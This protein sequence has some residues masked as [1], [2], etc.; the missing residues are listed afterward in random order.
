MA[1]I[2]PIDDTQMDLDMDEDQVMEEEIP[3]DSATS[4]PIL[5]PPPTGEKKSTLPLPGTL[6]AGPYRS[7]FALKVAET[8]PEVLNCLE[9]VNC[10]Y[11]STKG[12]P[13]TLLQLKQ[14]AQSL[15]VLIK[16]MTVSTMAAVIDNRN[17]PGEG[18]KEFHENES[19]DWLNDL[20]EPYKNG[21]RH[22]QMPLTSLLNTV[23]PPT[24]TNKPYTDI[25][26]MH[27]ADVRTPR[28]GIS[29]PYAT[30]QSLI[31]HANEVLELLD[32]EYSAKGGL[33]SILPSQ[34]QKEDRAKAETTLLGQLILYT[35]RLV[36]RV[37]DLEREYANSLDIIAGEAAVPLQALSQL[38]PH[39]RQPRELVYPQDRFVLVNA[40]DDVWQFLRNE[41]ERKEAA[42]EEADFKHY[43]RGITGEALWRKDGDQEFARG[44]TALD[45]TTRYYRLR[46]DPLE[47]VF[48]IPAYQKHPGTKVTREM[49]RQPTVVSVVKP[50]WPERA[51]MWEM[52]HRDDMEELKRLRSEHFQL[53]MDADNAKETAKGVFQDQQLKAQELRELKAKGS[54]A[55]KEAQVEVERLNAV[56]KDPINEVRMRLVEE[57][58][59]VDEVRMKT[60]A[61]EEE[62]KKKTE[63]LDQELKKA[64]EVTQQN[65]ELKSKEKSRV[66]RMET[67]MQERMR[68]NMERIDARD[69]EAAR[70]A[71]ATQ[72]KLR[73]L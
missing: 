73:A 33:L 55:L 67:T 8:T 45:I 69:A 29:L 50:V 62:F 6:F 49:E 63:A 59:A 58:R 21:D 17:I 13:P 68:E 10:S 18:A 41:F 14:H 2:T 48:V 51:S 47:T 30:H 72:D 42:D 70:A 65:M 19:Y 3:A 25:C 15:T 44:I 7:T 34:D 38:G 35:R 37:H 11:L 23:D 39:G 54:Q 24:F 57:S 16:N 66:K 32:H 46:N 5:N 31:E 27:R 61:A 64:Q 28:N 56:L 40:G 4:V 36:Q 60:V 22:H 20:T 1:R 12:L 43:D 71:N 52:R 9:H 26:P 53:Q